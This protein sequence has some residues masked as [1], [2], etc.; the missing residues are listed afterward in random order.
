MTGLRRAASPG[1]RLGYILLSGFFAVFAFIASTGVASAAR[2]DWCSNTP[3]AYS[4]PAGSGKFPSGG[5]AGCLGYFT[6]KDMYD[7]SSDFMRGWNVLIPP[8]GLALNATNATDFINEVE[9]YLN[10]GDTG[11]YAWNSVGAAFIIDNMLGKTG[12]SLCASGS[13]TWIDGVKY[14]ETHLTG[15]A[16]WEALVKGYESVGRINWSVSTFMPVGTIDSEHACLPSVGVT[17][18]TAAGRST[19]GWDEHDVAFR[20]NNDAS[21]SNL[22]VF[23]NPNGSVFKIRRDCGNV[24]GP[25]GPLVA[26]AVSIACNGFSQTPAVINPLTDGFSVTVR[27]RY[28][29]AAAAAAAFSG[30]T[31]NHMDASLL[32]PNGTTVASTA[33]PPSVSGAVASLTLS[34]IPA[35][36]QA[37]TFTVKYDVAGPRVPTISCTATL[38][39]GNL[40]YFTASGGDVAA[41][42]GFGA[43]CVADTT[44]GIKAYN[45]NNDAT[46]NDGY[47]GAGSSL[48]AFANGAISGFSTDTTNLAGAAS[49]AFSTNGIASGVD[50]RPSALAFANTGADAANG[51]YGG[52]FGR[53]G[54]WCTDDI[55]GSALAASPAVA[56]ATINLA[57]LPP[58][59]TTYKLPA[60]SVIGLGGPVVAAANRFVLSGQLPQGASLA[61][62]STGD[63]YISQSINP[64]AAYTNPFKIPQF[65]LA[66]QGGNLYVGPS[67]T[68]LTGI[69]AVQPNPGGGN[70]YT[71]A[72]SGA[73][74]YL[75]GQATPDANAT[76]AANAYDQCTNPLK[77]VGS[78]AA[79]QL[80]LGRT[81][82]SLVNSG[83]IGGNSPAE[84]FVY[85]PEL[86]LGNLTG[87]TCQQSASDPS[88]LYQA[89]TS[90][91]PVF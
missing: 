62:V 27:V 83:N 29:P 90:L 59:L 26:I 91:P 35:T 75:T 42:P 11:H 81:N 57:A 73:F 89:Y 63:V 77:F 58:G 45:L 10:E 66:V 34:P 21:T 85:T 68:T 61:L 15:P 69:Y 3:S 76:V 28:T 55:A 78:V 64:Y 32:R 2:N 1:G 47:F 54:S 14:A 67:L 18:A 65:T 56:P 22:I 8:S 37:G 4:L 12:G 20:R 41:G 17:C 84:D 25:I 39:I 13:C 24:V 86:W 16:G 80:K 46:L 23:H 36:N 50:A 19:P 44:A 71:C 60:G 33:G 87:P 5:R 51:L 49:K 72:D 70:L 48:A 79:A 88:C 52:G 74:K 31:P 30:P 82:G 53:S 7:P 9:N 43:G 38:S 40:P 6:G